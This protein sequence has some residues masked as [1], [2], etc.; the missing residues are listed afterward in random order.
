M[1]AVEKKHLDPEMTK[2]ANSPKRSTHS[3]SKPMKLRPLKIMICKML[4]C[5]TSIAVFT[6]CFLPYEWDGRI[7]TIPTRYLVM[8]ATSE[9]MM[10][11]LYDF[12][13]DEA[14]LRNFEATRFWMT[15]PIL[16]FLSF[17]YE[18]VPRYILSVSTILT[19][20]MDN[21]IVDPFIMCLSY[22]LDPIGTF[23]AFVWLLDRSI[24]RLNKPLTSMCF[25]QLFE[26]CIFTLI[27]VTRN[28]LNMSGNDS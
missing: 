26:F 7:Y 19:I 22:F 14:F 2:R 28:G 20:H 18:S 8:C 13:F 23:F 17:S 16:S 3:L 9:P 25:R 6:L 10:R 24:T 1:R 15:V 11:H 21:S 12:V 4:C 5:I 27:V